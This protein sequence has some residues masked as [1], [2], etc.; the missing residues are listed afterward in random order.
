MD[1]YYPS[2]PNL[3]PNSSPPQV[4]TTDSSSKINVYG[5]HVSDFRVFM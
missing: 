2:V 4:Y 3:V 5:L 1:T